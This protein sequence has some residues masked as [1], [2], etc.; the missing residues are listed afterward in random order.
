V[1]RGGAGLF[2]DLYP[3]QLAEPFASNPP[4]TTS[5]TIQAPG[6]NVAYGSAGDLS[7]I[8]SASYSALLSG[9]ANG[10]TYTQIS[11]NLAALGVPF[12]RPSLTAAPSNFKN[13]KYAQWNVA[14]QRSFGSRNSLTVNYVGNHGYD[15]LIR[16]GS[17]NSYCIA[18][19]CP[20]QNLPTARPDGRF[21]SI[22][23]YTNEGRSNYNGLVTSF[24]SNI[25]WG[26]QTNINYTW[27]HSL[28]DIS[29][30]GLQSYNLASPGSSLGF[31]IVPGALDLL[32]YSSS[33][34]D[35]RHTFSLNYVWDMPFKSGNKL[36]DVAIRGWSISGTLFALSGE[37][38]SAYYGTPTK[39]IGNGTNDVIL[40]SYLGGGE[41]DCG[42][43]STSTG[44]A[45][46]LTPDQ[47]GLPTAGAT[48]TFGNQARNAFRGPG[49]FNTD[50]SVLKRFRL[51]EKGMAISL[52]ANFYNILNHPNFA[53]PSGNLASPGT[54]GQVLSTATSSSSPYGNFQGAAVSGRLVQTVMKF[55][56]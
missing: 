30:G 16:D 14:V 40:A 48:N 31:T 15:E 26:F 21:G 23:Q 36:A 25:G 4:F 53:N 37:P 22:I 41:A 11:T 3:G 34:Y 1:I 20:F 44:T 17:V 33:D 7:S 29:N 5:F 45:V 2:S 12:S 8:G 51:T 32:N 50:M 18:A 39:Y 9:Y 43:P 54:F 35:I 49:Y 47:F 27:S 52:G 46:C 13:P 56:F 55:E 24:H 28:D 10:L 6:A 19:Y 42:H 38:F